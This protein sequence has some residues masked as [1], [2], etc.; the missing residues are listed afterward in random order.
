MLAKH[1]ISLAQDL[2]DFVRIGDYQ[3]S[4][5]IKDKVTKWMYIKQ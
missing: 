1:V 5:I 4:N 3:I 2:I